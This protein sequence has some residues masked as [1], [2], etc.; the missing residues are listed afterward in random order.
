MALNDDCTVLIT[1]S[2]DNTV[3]F[4][5]L[6]SNNREPIQTLSDFTDA[7]TSVLTTENGI[8]SASVDG[9]VR[10][11][12]MRSGRLYSDNLKDPITSVQL[13]EDGKAYLATCL[14]GTIR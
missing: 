12:D 10:V 6:R 9:F 8:V 5:D 7:V 3:K 13:T 14:H 4:W 11:Y 2:Y 1:A